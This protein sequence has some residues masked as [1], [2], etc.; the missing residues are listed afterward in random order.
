MIF[1]SSMGGSNS[2]PTKKHNDDYSD[3]D[4]KD[5]LITL[6]NLTNER[7]VAFIVSNGYFC[8]DKKLH[9]STKDSMKMEDLFK[10]KGI[11]YSP[12]VRTQVTYKNFIA[13]CKYLAEY[14]HYPP[15]CKTIMIYFAGHGSKGFIT[16]EAEEGMQKTSLRVDLQSIRS[17]FNKTKLAK[18]YFIDSCRGPE[19]DSGSSS[20]AATI[21]ETNNDGTTSGHCENLNSSDSGIKYAAQCSNELIAY[22]TLEGYV[23]YSDEDEGGSWTNTLAL[24]LRKSKRKSITSVLHDVNR[25][26]MYKPHGSKMA[27]E[28]QTPETTD[29]L[30]ADIYL[31]DQTGK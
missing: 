3:A 12:Y 5:S 11:N 23:A 22:A 2:K 30:I 25:L 7:G 21:N 13:T 27:T 24:Q 6:Q 19:T 9:S 1:S 8:S 15:T 29:R 20:S 16:M 14:E 10:E 28:F 26:M 31:W 18:I 4:V 17:L